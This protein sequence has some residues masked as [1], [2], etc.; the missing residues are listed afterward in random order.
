MGRRPAK[1]ER[2]RSS[3]GHQCEKILCAGDDNG[4]SFITPERGNRNVCDRSPRSA[5]RELSDLRS[6]SSGR[7]L[8][9]KFGEQSRRNRSFL[10]Q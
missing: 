5:V 7:N 2:E 8:G 4:R 6:S 3:L 9:K 10:E 1:K